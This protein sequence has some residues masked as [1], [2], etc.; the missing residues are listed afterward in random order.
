MFVKH[1]TEMTGI[2]M[3]TIGNVM[4][5]MALAEG[6]CNY[7]AFLKTAEGMG[8]KETVNDALSEKD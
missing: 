6:S 4:W 8:G 2:G 5:R 1:G 3:A 7:Q